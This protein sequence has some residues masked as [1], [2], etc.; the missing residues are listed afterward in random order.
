MEQN[1]LEDTKPIETL[2]N[3]SEEQKTR[4]KMY[5]EVVTET[6]EDKYKEAQ[7]EEEN[8]EMQEEAEKA[9]ALQNIEKAEAI[10]TDEEKENE[11]SSKKEIESIF[12]KI[13]N[14]WQGLSKGQKIGISLVIALFV[15]LLILGIVF[16]CLKLTKKEDTTPT[17]VV[18]EA[19]V[20]KQNYYYKDGTLYFLNDKEEEIGTYTCTNKNSDLCYVALNSYRDNFDVA[21]LET[22][23]GEEKLQDVPIYNENYVFIIDSK[24]AT[25]I[26]IS[27][28]SIKDEKVEE[29]YYD[30]KAYDDNLVIIKDKENKYGLLK[31]EDKITELI[32]PQYTYLGMIDGEENLVAKD[33]K[34]YKIIDQSNKSQSSSLSGSYEIKYYNNTFIVA[35]VGG[36]YNA[37]DYKANLVTGGYTFITVSDNYAALIDDQ[38]VYVVDDNGL[39]YN[40]DGVELKTDNYVTT[41]VYNEDG[42]LEET[43]KSFE[44][45]TSGDNIN[46]VIYDEEGNDEYYYLDKIVAQANEK[47]DYFNYFDGKLYFYKDKDKKELIGSYTCNNENTISNI[48]D[49]YTSCVPASDT[50]Y[51]S[52][53]MQESGY[54]SRKAM[55]PLVNN[56]YVFITDGAN[57]VYLYDLV[58]K[59]TIAP[60]TSV[61]TYTDDNNYKFTSYS[62]TLNVIAV[63]KKSG[64][65]GMITIK[66]DSV[67]AVYSF[68]YNKMEKLGNY[69]LA[70]SSDSKWHLLSSKNTISTSF[71]GKVVGYSSNLKYF[72]ILSGS[73]YG[74]YNLN[75][76]MV[77]TTTY[78]YVELYDDYFAA[79]N[80]NHELKL[81]N[82]Q[83]EE[84][85]S[86]TVKIGDYDYTNTN[87][88]AF[89]V[90]KDGNIYKV[91]VYNGSTYEEQDID[92]TPSEEETTE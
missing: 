44:V 66:S 78:S 36:E 22:S 26:P 51:E 61:N 68:E 67:S 81:Y 32:K 89:K 58:K 14:K 9:L 54:S 48:K 86:Q 87:T 50:I 4:A 90:S 83:G 64:L 82:Y 91:L 79:V 56:R 11:E 13:K 74:V 6:R 92:T 16:L 24:E 34:G 76:E 3:L 65:Y 62:G 59:S 19:P 63:S 18:E 46:V 88:P 43:K 21:K 69:I 27:L 33:S 57:I 12:T 42:E 5:E 75:A 38:R 28:Y 25:N 23:S 71:P 41:Y 35:I 40:E 17:E 20:M 29:T 31:I 39:K 15:I 2:K 49:I 8:R 84:L 55:T 52:N 72:K 1:N 45:D 85:S 80:N 10:L 37:Y 47:Y 77:S 53:D 7:I 30:V 73:N 70:Q 60:Y